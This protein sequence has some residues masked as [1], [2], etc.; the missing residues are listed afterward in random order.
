MPYVKPDPDTRRTQ[1]FELLR[2]GNQAKR[3]TASK[4]RGVE[5]RVS[6]EEIASLQALALKSLQARPSDHA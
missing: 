6:P 1:L 3:M 4:Y 2:Q 5:R